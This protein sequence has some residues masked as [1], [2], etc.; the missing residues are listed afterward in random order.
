MI[1]TDILSLTLGTGTTAATAADTDL[2]TIDT[3]S[4][5]TV[6]KTSTDRQIKFDYQ[7]LSTEGSDGTYTEMKL[8]NASNDYDRVVFEGIEWTENGTDEL[9][10]TKRYFIKAG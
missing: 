8:H 4:A 10:I 5:K 3:D 9:F 6:T 2:E 1:S 7:L